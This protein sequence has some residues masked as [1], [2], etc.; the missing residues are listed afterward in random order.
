MT[1]RYVVFDRDGTLIEYVPYLSDWSEVRFRSG[2][3]ETLTSLKALGFR[4]GIVTN[5]SVIA[6]KLASQEAVKTINAR[7]V[8]AIRKS[9]G[10]EIDFVQ[11]C[12]HVPE[13]ACPCRKPK[14]GLLLNLIP[15][16]EIECE[17]SYMAGDSESDMLFGKNLGMRTILVQQNY[18]NESLTSA[19]HIVSK[20]D[21]ILEVVQSYMDE[22]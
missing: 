22:R 20:F 6:R 11:V 15:K 4:F 7:I 5:Q 2:V 12:P 14:P 17:L 3:F 10:V 21:K 13:D 9:S 18:R 16:L 1:N 8:S 19:D